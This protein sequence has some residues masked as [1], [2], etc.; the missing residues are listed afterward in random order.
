[1]G[2]NSFHNE[3]A[4]DTKVLNYSTPNFVDFVYS[5]ENGLG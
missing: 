3:G 4:K 1:M 2:P 5:F